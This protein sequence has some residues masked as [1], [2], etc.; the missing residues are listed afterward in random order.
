MTAPSTVVTDSGKRRFRKWIQRT[1]CIAT[2]EQISD[3]ANL[4]ERS[5]KNHGVVAATEL[6]VVKPYGGY[7]IENEVFFADQ[8]SQKGDV[9]DALQAM[10]PKNV[11]GVDLGSESLT[12][13][14]GDRPVLQV[15]FGSGS[16][17]RVGRFVA[18]RRAAPSAG[19]SAYLSSTDRAWLAGVA[20]ELEEQFDGLVP[21]WGR[22]LTKLRRLLETFA[23][24]AYLLGVLR[25]AGLMAPDQR[26]LFIAVL[27]LF[28]G[29]VIPWAITAVL[30]WAVPDFEVLAAGQ[31]SSVSRKLT[32]CVTAVSL[33]ASVVTVL[34]LFL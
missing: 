15:S 20:A 33:L 24:G 23:V 21:S 22:H 4:V 11:I 28:G 1:P 32:A 8:S 13:E 34:S 7:G 2:V 12:P 31:Q 19:L 6:E 26:L 30:R 9:E 27:S 16:R 5:L 18:A 29:F 25:F 14:S 3:V 10:S 17:V